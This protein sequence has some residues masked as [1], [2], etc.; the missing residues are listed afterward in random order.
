MHDNIWIQGRLDE[1]KHSPVWDKHPLGCKWNRISLTATKLVLGHEAEVA[2]VAEWCSNCATH[3]NGYQE[4]VRSSKMIILNGSSKSAKY[5]VLTLCSAIEFQNNHFK[6]YP[7]YSVL[8]FCIQWIN[9]QLVLPMYVA[10]H[11]QL[12]W[13][14]HVYSF[15]NFSV[16][17]GTVPYSFHTTEFKLSWIKIAFSALSSAVP[18]EVI[19]ACCF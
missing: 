14:T 11:V 19:F 4:A 15:H 12:N 2:F 8:L 9:Y 17:P 5:P 3:T 7:G 16:L 6:L 1:G 10:T 13:Q 18:I